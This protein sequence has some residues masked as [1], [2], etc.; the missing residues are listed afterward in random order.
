MRY[1]ENPVRDEAKNIGVI[2]LCPEQSKAVS[3]FL[4]SRTGLDS[5]SR[6]YAVLSCIIA[7]YEV[8]L[9]TWTMKELQRLYQECTNMLQFSRPGTH[10]GDPEEVLGTLFQERVADPG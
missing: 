8:E 7:R 5:E 4:L 10:L 3:K 9:G 1:V 2:V 6:E